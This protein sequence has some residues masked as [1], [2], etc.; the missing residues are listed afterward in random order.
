MCFS[1]IQ[2][3]INS[4][5]S[6]KNINSI[7]NYLKYLHLGQNSNKSYKNS[8]YNR[9]KNQK[10]SSTNINYVHNNTENNNYSNIYNN[11][12]NFDYSNNVFTKNTYNKKN[13]ID[14]PKGENSYNNSAIKEIP[15]NKN[16]YYS[17]RNKIN[18]QKSNDSTFNSE[19]RGKIE[20]SSQ[21]I[22]CPEEL[23]YLYVTIFQKGNGMNFDKNK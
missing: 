1:Q 22:E 3:P 12:Y 6:P 11:T 23:H 13:L 14:I 20:I 7:Q 9:G 4:S 15:S 10:L 21:Y 2:I 5:C 8:P 16:I 17:K 19:N 18:N